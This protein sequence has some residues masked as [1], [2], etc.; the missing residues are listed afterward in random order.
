MHAL[1]DCDSYVCS[2]L[3]ADALIFIA[4][5]CSKY[6]LVQLVIEAICEN[7]I[8]VRIEKSYDHKSRKKNIAATEKCCK[9][10]DE[11]EWKLQHCRNEGKV[12]GE[13]GAEG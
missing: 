11:K 9:S 12:R 5:D 7:D 2:F 3:Q 4:L 8:D 1:L 10:R 13:M 6:Q